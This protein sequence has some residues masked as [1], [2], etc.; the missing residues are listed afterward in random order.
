MSDIQTN[1]IHCGDN[2]DIMRSMESDSIDLV[3]ADP[4]FFTQ[5]DWGEFDDRFDNIDHYITWLS[6]RI[7]E[8]HRLLK[9]SGSIYLHCDAHASH[10]IKVAMDRI[11]GVK[12]FNSDIIWERCVAKG[13]ASM[14][15]NS[16]DNILFY[17]KK[18]PG[19]T[20][21]KQYKPYKPQTLAMFK[22]TDDGGEFTTGVAGK[23]E[24]AY[25]EKYPLVDTNGRYHLR[26]L[27]RSKSMGERP[28]LVYEYNGFTPNKYGWRMIKEKV[29]KLDKEGNLHWNSNGKPYRKIRPDESAYKFSDMTAPKTYREVSC[30]SPMNYA[31]DLPGAPRGKFASQSTVNAPMYNKGNF[32][33][34]GYGE[35]CPQNG[36]RWTE[37]VMRQKI[38]DGLI[39]I[40]PGC[41]PRQKRYLTDAL[42]VPLNNIWTDIP[43]NKNPTYPTQKPEALLDRII[44]SSSN[45]G[46]I[47][48]DPFNGSG[49]TVAVAKKL[50]RKWIGI[51]Q[52]EN[53]IKLTEERLSKII[54]Q[55]R[56]NKWM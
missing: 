17:S 20:F 29:E 15:S 25:K 46:D 55:G 22:H 1:T 19:T 31:S 33:D 6:E 42:G 38:A 32:Y 2:L 21:N 5:K 7:T 40:K 49:T 53:A 14:Y 56:L 23:I 4:P 50:G 8:I 52:N 13:N 10:Y 9:P 3:Y 18:K 24:S 44:K 34:L 27:L 54:N 28:N 36:Y 51:D 41:V 39:V 35:K 30:D 48:L 12:N 37:E 11:F 47:V 45:M 26:T 43:N 16:T